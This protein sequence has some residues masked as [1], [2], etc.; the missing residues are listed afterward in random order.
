MDY[1]VH[2]Y[3]LCFII[4]AIIVNFMA[5]RIETMLKNCTHVLDHFYRRLCYI[6]LF[7]NLYIFVF[8]KNFRVLL[9]LLVARVKQAYQD[10]KDTLDHQDL[11]WP[12]QHLE[13]QMLVHWMSDM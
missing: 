4:L 2:V 8:Q 13:A 11:L 10:L 5:F 3:I 6:K 9:V 7:H 1:F 12:C